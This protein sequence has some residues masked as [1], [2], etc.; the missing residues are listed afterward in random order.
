MYFSYALH[1]HVVT[2]AD[3]LIAYDHAVFHQWCMD[4]T[5]SSYVGPQF[6][7]PLYAV[8]LLGSHHFCCDFSSLLCYGDEGICSC[9]ALS[10]STE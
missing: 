5:D 4:T 6:S 1:A 10:T 2:L 8:A 9:R 3:I 7:V